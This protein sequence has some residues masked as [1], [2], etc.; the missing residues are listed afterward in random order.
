MVTTTRTIGPLH[1]EDL[2]PHR[3]EDLIRQLLYDFRPWN[4]LEAT[5]RSGSD[6]GFDVRGVEALGN[7][8]FAVLEEEGKE[9]ENSE[10]DDALEKVWLIQCKREKA[11]GPEKLKKYLLEIPEEE[12]K[13]LH[14]L[15]FAA[16]CDFSKKSRDVFFSICRDFGLAECHLWGKAEL[17]DMLFQPKNDYLLFA[18]FGISLQIRKRSL[19]TK[20]RSLI[21]TRRKIRSKINTRSGVSVLIL[22]VTDTRYPYLDKN[23]KL[24]R[25]NR[26]RWQVLQT[27][28]VSYDGLIISI[29]K[30]LAYVHEDKLHWDYNDK[31]KQTTTWAH[32]DRWDGKELMG[33]DDAEEKVLEEWRKLPDQQKA[34]RHLTGKIHYEKILDIDEL[35]DDFFEGPI[36]YTSEWHPIKGPFDGFWIYVKTLS[37]EYVDPQEDKLI[38]FFKK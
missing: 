18:Y 14:G 21:A 38:D 5:G 25:K 3:F 8:N 24:A 9:V 31:I 11:I 20:I 30:N 26:G 17:E 34:W 7:G 19:K 28:E 33:R 36:I 32:E 27:E 13:T 12:R 1:L 35:G 15:I 23:K 6:D 37:N 10:E 22:D 4:R 16:A 29:K 2:E